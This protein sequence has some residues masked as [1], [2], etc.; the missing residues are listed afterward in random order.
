MLVLEISPEQLNRRS[1]LLGQQV[2]RQMTWADLPSYM[3]DACLYTPIMRLLTS[4]LLPLYMHRYEIRKQT[5][6][7]LVPRQ[8]NPDPESYLTQAPVFPEPELQN[9]PPPAP[10]LFGSRI[11]DDRIAAGRNCLTT[12]LKDYQPSSI[13][14]SALERMLRRCSIERIDVLLI[15]VP[16]MTEHRVLYS[17][18]IEAAYRDYIHSLETKYSCRFVDFR[19]TIIYGRVRPRETIFGAPI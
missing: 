4:R 19:D 16:V 12:W 13:A 14:T 6:G 1:P 18:K 5:V 2:I 17:P 15:G 7:A 11:S 8:T 9:V 3:P 10:P